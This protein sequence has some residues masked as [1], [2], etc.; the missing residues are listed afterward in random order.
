MD[1]V[2]LTTFASEAKI[3]TTMPHGH[4]TKSVPKNGPYAQ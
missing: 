3:V 2:E 4:N 1:G